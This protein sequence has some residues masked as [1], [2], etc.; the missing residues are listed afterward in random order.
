MQAEGVKKRVTTSNLNMK[1][2]MYFSLAT[3]NR[4]AFMNKDATKASSH[5]RQFFGDTILPA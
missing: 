4:K 5:L 3:N 2:Q 1:Q